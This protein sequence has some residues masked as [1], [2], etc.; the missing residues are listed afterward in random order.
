MTF[1]T[2]IKIVGQEN[3]NNFLQFVDFQNR[4]GYTLAMKKQNLFAYAYY[5]YFSYGIA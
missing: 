5:F 2:R 4:L 1:F 3:I